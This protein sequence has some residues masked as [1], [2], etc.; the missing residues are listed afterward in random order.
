MAAMALT[1][2]KVIYKQ[3]FGPLMPGAHIAP[4]P[5]CLHCK[6]QAEKVRGVQGCFFG[7]GSFPARAAHP[8]C[9]P[10]PVAD[11]HAQGHAG[12]H[13]A[14]YVPPFEASD[15]ARWCCNAPLEALEWMLVQQVRARA[16]LW[17]VGRARER[18]RCC[19]AL[20]C[21]A[22]RVDRAE[23]RPRVCVWGGHAGASARVWSAATTHALHTHALHTHTHTHC[24]HTHTR[25]SM[26]MRRCT[27]RTWRRSS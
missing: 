12:Y 2:S 19:V 10:A 20:R 3:H 6:V 24:T 8:M 4:Y 25:M 1:S 21:V 15:G 14:P 23:P 26:H 17:D 22:S 18:A 13:L 27:P 7:G 5:Y 11:A 16:P 9:V